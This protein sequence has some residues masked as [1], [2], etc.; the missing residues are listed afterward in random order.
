M[1]LRPPRSTRTDTLCPY[2]TL[3]RSLLVSGALLGRHRLRAA[4]D[5]ILIDVVR[6]APQAADDV[7]IAI[8]VAVERAGRHVAGAQHIALELLGDVA[9]VRHLVEV[10]SEEPTSELQSLMRN[11]Y[12]VFCLNKNKKMRIIAPV[13]T[14]RQNEFV[15][16]NA[17]II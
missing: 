6:L 16:V 8:G 1:I 5:E 4:A 15:L 12:A 11:S 2:T 13:T 17:T 9:D 10:R 7:Q 14:K 3:F